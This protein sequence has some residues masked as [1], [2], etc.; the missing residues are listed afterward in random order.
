MC[1]GQSA[2]EVGTTEVSALRNAPSSDSHFAHTWPVQALG[3]VE[4]LVKE[5]EIIARAE[6]IRRSLSEETLHERETKAVSAPSTDHQALT[7]PPPA[8]APNTLAA[9]TLGY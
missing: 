9:R 6:A 5:T 1:G 3:S 2:I 4:D 7:S 8:G